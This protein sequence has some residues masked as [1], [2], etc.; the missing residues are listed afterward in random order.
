MVSGTSSFRECAQT[1]VCPQGRARG[2][3]RLAPAFRLSRVQDVHQGTF[4]A[5]STQACLDP[6]YLD[7]SLR[8]QGTR[9]HTSQRAP[10]PTPHSR[11][12]T[13]A[14][15]QQTTSTTRAGCGLAS[16]SGPGP[17]PQRARG[18]PVRSGLGQPGS[19]H[20]TAW[21]QAQEPVTGQRSHVKATKSYVM[22][23]AVTRRSWHL[24]QHTKPDLHEGP[25][26][27]PERL[28][29]DARSYTDGEGPGHAHVIPR[30]LAAHDPTQGCVLWAQ[31]PCPAAQA[32]LQSGGGKGRRDPRDG[33]GSRVGSCRSHCHAVH[34]G[35]GSPEYGSDHT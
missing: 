18:T 20:Q 35:C 10:H 30:K 26:V 11:A 13:W 9:Q 33:Q 5:S 31:S 6:P 28:P 21:P 23:A 16:G 22:C 19:G 12:G 34:R 8:A 17:G 32:Q 1:R 15:R 25:R 3:T 27:P 29:L 4:T 14:L 2:D 7:S 24:G